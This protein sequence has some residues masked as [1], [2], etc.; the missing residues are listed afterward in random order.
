M[1]SRPSGALRA[2]TLSLALLGGPALAAP[3][4]F[5]G[6]YLVEEEQST[7]GALVEDVAPDSP[8]AQAGLR[9]GDRVISCN[10]QATPN[11][12]ALIGH[13][14]AANPG[15]S[16]DLRVSR[17]GW[18]RALK[19]TL[20][21]RPGATPSAPGTPTTPQATPARPQAERGFLGVYM[22][23]GAEGE[24]IVDGVMPGSPAAT[25]G[26]QQGD[27]VKTLNGQR[28]ADPSALVGSLGSMGPGT[29]ITLGIRRGG[30]LGRDM[31]VEVTLGRRTSETTAPAPR[32]QPTQPEATP[33]PSARRAPYFGV[34][35]LDDEGKGPLKVDDVQANSPAERFGVRAGDVILEVGATKVATI[36]QFV[37]TMEGK[38][39]GDVIVLKIER[40]GWKSELRV[41]LGARQE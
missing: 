26:L 23:Q 17:D 28:V 36:E 10:G 3:G 11:G 38:F 39:A 4:G 7:N 35:L 16:L 1:T 22:R 31:N 37:K 20:G 5:L 32:A 6:T 18:E 24:A 34:A 33:A 8:A 27:H 13:L 25:A 41:T 19:V 12:K 29:K 40:D 21:G 15:Q 14:T 2:L 30:A 9:K